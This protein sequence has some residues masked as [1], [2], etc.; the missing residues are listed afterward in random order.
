MS[1]DRNQSRTLTTGFL[2]DLAGRAVAEAR[3]DGVPAEAV[4]RFVGALIGVKPPKQG[5]SSEWEEL[6]EAIAESAWDP[7]GAAVKRTPGRHEQ[8]V[9][10]KA[11]SAGAGLPPYPD[12]TVASTAEGQPISNVK[13]VPPAV[14]E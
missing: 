12:I 1:I 6:C 4:I 5:R 14:G 3:P 11:V 13:L 9:V 10:S 2:I 8:R 7:H